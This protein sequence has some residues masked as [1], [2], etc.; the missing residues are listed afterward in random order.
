LVHYAPE[1]FLTDVDDAFY[2]AQ[3]MRAWTL[4]ALFR[5]FLRREYD[6]EWFRHPRAGAFVRDRWR[7]GQRY[8]A[9]ELA[10]FLGFDGLDMTPLV[11]EIQ[12][13]LA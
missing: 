6:E 13:G 10:Q 8:T 7:E 5:N 1:E 11:S 9:D 12:A 2:S 4:E 3:Y